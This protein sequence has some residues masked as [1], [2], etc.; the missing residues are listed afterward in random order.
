MPNKV[1]I[2]GVVESTAEQQL[3]RDQIRKIRQKS[4]KVLQNNNNN[5][6]TELLADAPI[7]SKN[8]GPRGE[9]FDANYQGGSPI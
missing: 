1:G 3:Q 5:S 4:Y 9:Y 7:Q 2:I 8:N 6:R